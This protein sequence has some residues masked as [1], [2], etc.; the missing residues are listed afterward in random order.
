VNLFERKLLVH[1]KRTGADGEI[2]KK[3]AKTWD[4]PYLSGVTNS[5][6]ICGAVSLKGGR[7]IRQDRQ[8]TACGSQRKTPGAG[9][10]PVGSVAFLVGGLLF[11]Q[12][13]R[14]LKPKNDQPDLRR[15]L[16]PIR[17]VGACNAPLERRR[18]ELRPGVS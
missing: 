17:G 1:S 9:C 12:G 7:Q 4:D 3:L 11:E 16:G 6:R 18:A 2:R 5:D 8:A 15:R 14:G 13:L 10:R